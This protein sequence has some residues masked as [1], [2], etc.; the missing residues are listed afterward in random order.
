MAEMLLQ[1]HEGYIHVIPALSNTWQTGSF[2]GLTA[3]GGFVVDAS[4]DEYELTELSVMSRKGGT[5]GV[6]GHYQVMS[7]FEQVPSTYIDG[8]TYVEAQE[9]KRYNYVKGE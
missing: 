4:W 5:L 3:R 9:G 6:L 1:S 2:K 7:D 8:V